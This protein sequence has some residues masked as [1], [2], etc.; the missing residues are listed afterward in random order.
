MSFFSRRTPQ[1]HSA[2]RPAEFDPSLE[3]LLSR[4][5]P[6]R[7]TRF[8]VHVVIEVFLPLRGMAFDDAEPSNCHRLRG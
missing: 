4:L 2:V 3:H 6:L 8:D 7:A 5:R 1:R